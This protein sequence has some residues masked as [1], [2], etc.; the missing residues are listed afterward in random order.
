MRLEGDSTKS[1][2]RDC[3][4]FHG[5]IPGYDPAQ[6]NEA[7]TLLSTLPLYKN[8]KFKMGHKSRKLKVNVSR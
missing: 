5:N 4:S 6:E 3:L 1:P 8:E 7:M 2:R